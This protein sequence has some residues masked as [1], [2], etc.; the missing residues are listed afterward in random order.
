MT[1]ITPAKSKAFT[2]IELLVVISIIALL[3]AILLPALSKARESAQGIQCASNIRQAF[4]A[5]TYYCDDHNGLYPATNYQ[6]PNASNTVLDRT[7]F[8]ALYYNERYVKHNLT[9]RYSNNAVAW[10][11]HE[12]NC[13]TETSYI[14]YWYDQSNAEYQ[15]SNFG[16]NYQL[17]NRLFP[18]I[19]PG[20]KATSPLPRDVIRNPSKVIF[21]ADDV[22]ESGQFARISYTSAMEMA[23]RHLQAANVLWFDGH[24]SQL[25]TSPSGSTN[26]AWTDDY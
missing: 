23:F 10:L 22:S 15:S 21:L 14:G 3:I 16:L 18:T 2:L 13:P 26:Q 20:V 25:T 6:V 8:W 19:L 4:M 12:L 7:W 11:G 24:V 1:R 5:M 9:K 17:Y